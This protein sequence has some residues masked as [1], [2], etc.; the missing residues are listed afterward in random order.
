VATYPLNWKAGWLV[1][2]AFNTTDK[3]WIFKPLSNYLAGE[4]FSGLR[5]ETAYPV[6]DLKNPSPGLTCSNSNIQAMSW[7]GPTRAYVYVKNLTDCWVRVVG[8][9]PSPSSQSGSVRVLGLQPGV[10]TVEKWS[11]SD[12]NV[13]TQKLSTS[14]ITVGSDGVASVSVSLETT[15][16]TYDYAYK[17][18]SQG[19][20]NVS[21]PNI[22]LVTTV[23]RTDAKPGDIVTYTVTY[24][25]N[26][27]GAA[28]NVVVSCDI[29]V[30]TT[31]VA[32]SGG[33]LKGGQVTWT[34]PTLAVGGNG[35]VTFKVTVN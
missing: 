22:T 29:P 14:S 13:S 33:T 23:D 32:G 6:T 9:G 17:I 11:T 35:L 24:K 26:G 12:T 1:G 10:Y 28:S 20:T 4:D 31:Y 16:G 8:R 21:Q 34:I 19:N 3:M 25:N 2:K 27:E 15:M 18:K 30:N 7:H 5:S